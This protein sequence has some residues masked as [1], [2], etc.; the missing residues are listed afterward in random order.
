MTQE[1]HIEEPD[2]IKNRVLTENTAQGVLN[3]L[4]TQESNRARMRTRWIWELLQNA[5]DTKATSVSIEFGPGEITFQHNGDE[6][7]MDDVAH[8]IYHGSTKIE[9]EGT[10]GRYGSGFLTTHLLS[11]TIDIS[12]QL[13]NEQSFKFALTR[14]VGSVEALSESM[15]R[16]WAD[17]NE[18]RSAPT[19]DKLPTRFRYPIED[20]ADDVVAKG[21]AMLKK[22]APF[23]VAFN[24]VFSR[25]DL[26]KSPD[27]TT[28][29]EVTERASLS[30]D[31]LQE[32]T[33]LE[34]GNRKKYLLAESGKTSV[35]VLMKPTSDGSKTLMPINN[36]P[37]LFLGFPL[38]GTKNFSFPAVINSFE[39]TP[40][41][42]RDGVFLGQ[43]ENEANRE[44]E[45]VIKKA[46]GLLVKLVQFVAESGYRN[47]YELAN[48]PAIP[49]PD[50]LN[51]K[52]LQGTLEDQFIEKV[53][54][55]PAV[56]CELDPITPKE[57]I[58]PFAEQDTGVEALWDLLGGLEE[59][60]Q[61]LPRESEAVGWCDALKSWAVVQ[62]GKP[63]FLFGEAMDGKKLVSNIEE[64]THKN[65]NCG[66]IEDLRNLLREDEDI[67]A[68]EWLNRLH[69]FLNKDGLREE[70]SEYHIVLDQDGFLDK[71]SNLHC[72][73]GI[74][75]ELK[76]IAELLG[77]KVRQKLRD[78]R[79]TALAD[80]IGAGE[81]NR[82][83]VVQNIISKINERAEADPDD[84][85]AQASVRLF[86]WI[87][88]QEDWNRLRGFPVFTVEKA[89][90]DNWRVIKLERGDEN[91]DQPLAP[92]RAWINDLQR[93]SDLFPKRYILADDFFKAVS[94]SDVWQ[95][96]DEQGFLKRN[97][98]ITKEVY[99]PQFLPDEVLTDDED[100]ETTQEDHETTQQV[101]VTNIAFL[102]REDIGI[103]ARVRQNHR[104]ARTFWHFLTEWLILNDPKG[105]E[106]NKA[107][108]DCGNPHEYYPAEWLKPLVKNRWVP[109]GNRKSDKAT[110]NSLAHLLRGS[111]WKLNSLNENPDVVKLLKA[112]G[113]TQFDLTRE[114]VAENP[115]TRQELDNAFTDILAAAGRDINYLNHARE[116]IVALKNDENLPEVIKDRQRQKQIVHENQHLGKLVE[117]LVRESLENEGFAV[118]RE[119]IGSDFEIE[120]DSVENEKEM[121]I[122]VE[123]ENQ[124]WLVEVKATRGQEVRMTATQARKAV[125][126][127]DRFLLCVV[128]VGDSTP[129]R[130]TVRDN[131]WFVENIG[132]RVDQLCD[133]LNDLEKLRD[134][135]T[136]DESSGVQLEVLSGT[137]RIRVA[138]FVWETDGFPLED[139]AERLG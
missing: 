67:E 85:F 84:K 66:K 58:L 98:I 138:S 135:I 102:T 19:S 113:V 122:K 5:R 92:V 73:Q 13:D 37:R 129:D 96:L 139:L 100:H 20:R 78:T 16:A 89:N 99:F 108:C 83:Y 103:M 137:A 7:K 31:G 30:Q 57:S 101:A 17:F 60:R 21:I 47:V 54:Q 72:D 22:C 14:E 64:K 136:D 40:T 117:K 80:Q 8:L 132:G 111:E 36:T 75:E 24:E 49:E 56:L 110:A 88:D 93:F 115:E 63:M 133:G 52:W 2:A 127:R 104:L 11:P 68:V 94:D 48:V 45:A 120:H 38:I 29:F 1:N 70:V 90:D 79:L 126:Q 6:F 61:K 116:Y 26:I 43:A 105:L 123:R 46:C 118:N 134:K 76:D 82:E 25:I 109:M 86:K 12:G 10:L 9:D 91:G 106:I 81:W 114:F 44:N 42:H 35:A 15:N 124:T 130:D 27:E 28:S 51:R 62:D 97:V 53:R 74:D 69:D 131:I 77:W 4:K 107:D 128:P 33:V 119:P 71:L 65:G 59:Y 50:W 95:T 41:E 3:N 112:I 32:I 125:E 87:V 18:S 55:T 39:F 23:V 34:N 121:G